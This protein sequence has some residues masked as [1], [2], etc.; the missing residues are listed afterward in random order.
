MPTP[1]AARDLV[2]GLPPFHEPNADL[3]VAVARAGHLGVLDLGSD[4]A[5][6]R[7]ALARLL[8]EPDL[9]GVEAWVAGGVHD[10]RS[11]AMVAALTAPLA[12]RCARV[13][14][15]MGTAGDVAALRGA[16]TTVAALHE[17]VT[18]GAAGCLDARAAGLAPDFA[19]VTAG[20]GAAGEP[21]PR[22]LDVAIVGMACVYPGAE[23]L[24]Q[25]WANVVAGRD[26]VGPVPNSRWRTEPYPDAPADRGGFIPPV[27]F[28]ALAYGIPP[29]ALASIEPVKLL[30]LE[31]AARALDDAGYATRPF[32]RSRASVIFGAAAGGDLSAAYGLRTTLPG[33]L[34][35]DAGGAVPAALDEFLPGLAEDSFPGVLGNVIAGRLGLGGVNYAV[36]AAGA[37]SLAALDL[38]CK[39]LAAGTSDVVLCGGADTRGGIHDYEMFASAHALSPSG[40]GAT[41]DAAADGI[42]LGEGVGCVVLKRLADAERDGDRVYAV[43]KGIGGASDGRSPGLTAAPRAEG[44]RLALERAYAMAGVSPAEVGL[45]EAHGTGTVAGDRAELATLTA[46]FTAAGAAPGGCAVGSVKAQIGHSRCAAGLAGLIKVACALHTGTRPGT[47]HLT[48]PNAYWDPATSPFT[49][50]T[51][52]ARPWADPAARRHAG[53]SAFGFGG[54]NFHAVLSGYDGADPP[55]HGLRDWP[56]ELFALRGDVTGALAAL[57]E[58]VTANNQ[59]GRPWR[60]AELAATM[61]ARPGP[62]LAAFTA[63]SLDDLQDRLAAGPVPEPA[64]GHPGAVALLF[65]GQGSQRAGMTA[66]LFTAFPRLQGLLRLTGPA[67]AAALF[68]PAAFSQ[69]ERDRQAAAITDTRMAQPALGVAGLA[70]WEL[71]R[72]CGVRPDMAAGHG[73]GELAALCAAGA[74]DQATLIELS[75]ARAAAI[76]AAAGGDPGAMASVRA[77]ASQVT[78][79]LDET[80]LGRAGVVIA[81]HNAPGQVVVSGPTAPLEATVTALEAAGLS[82]RRLP[83]ACA[84]HSPVVAPAAAAMAAALAAKPVSAPRFP[85]YANS[86]AEPYQ[87]APDEVRRLLAAQVA[88]PVRFAEQ[89]EAMYAAGARVFVEAGPGRTLSGL[90][91]QILA[92]RPH[93]AIACDGPGENGLARL[94]TALAELAGAGV[95]VDPALL[96]AGRAA[97]VSGPPPRAAW[98]VDGHLVRTADGEPVAGRLRPATA[99]PRLPLGSVTERGAGPGSGRDQVMAEFLRNTRELIAVQRDVLLGYLGATPP[100]AAAWPG[101]ADHTERGQALPAPPT[102]VPAS[103]A[104]DA[105]ATCPSPGPVPAGPPTRAEIAAAVVAVITDWLAAHAGGTPGTEA[106]PVFVPRQRPA[107]RPDDGAGDPAPARP[108]GDPAGRAGRDGAAVGWSA[109][110]AGAAESAGATAASVTVPGAEIPGPQVPSVAVPGAHARAHDSGPYVLGQQD[111]RKP[112]VQPVTAAAQPRRLVLQPAALPP[113]ARPG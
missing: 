84:F 4:P 41:F 78:A 15:L 100:P 83:V 80:G 113:A 39:E 90:A 106:G 91:G 47:I 62:V 46:V 69:E 5:A 61:A 32:D 55:V 1:S 102:P 19:A 51:G 68:P 99:A 49:F 88:D 53:V 103:P 20:A 87:Q 109:P 110:G 27:P 60:L 23:G 7:A 77:A 74:Y 34:E 64:P 79:L 45:V 57:G 70:V 101:S 8:A 42:A 81:N 59:A 25:F 104:P 85:V 35:P 13:G 56:A 50:T 26:A 22:P 3:V 94:V 97:P 89:V 58:L 33:Y 24:G 96:F 107:A 40:R 38:A 31:V 18:V 17:Q 73:Y 52:Q 6:G 92:G 21:Q 28:D 30:A 11:A 112:N 105:A 63:A 98:T 10:E 95:P 14:V 111:A 54:S 12:G 9:T 44:Q 16:V 65:P 67:V 43:V 71:L 75:H 37:S 108:P 93:T 72:T 2:L 29:A 76:L 66:D 82:A 36:D 48:E 86:T